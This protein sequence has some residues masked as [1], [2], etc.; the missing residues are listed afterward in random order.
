MK[1]I[2]NFMESN[3]RIRDSKGQKHDLILTNF[4]K[5]FFNKGPLNGKWSG[6]IVNK[7]R[8]L[9][10]SMLDGMETLLLSKIYPGS[11][12]PVI[13]TSED[14]AIH[15]MKL[16][17][18]MIDDCR[19]KFLQQKKGTEGRVWGKQFANKSEIQVFSGSNPKSIRGPK[20]LKVTL[21]EFAHSIYQKELL[22][23]ASPM[24]I[25]G[26]FLSTISTPMGINNEYWKMYKN[27]KEIGYETITQPIFEDMSKF[28]VYDS[29]YK[30]DLKVVAPW[31]DLTKLESDRIRDQIGFLQEYCCNPAESSYTLFNNDDLTNSVIQG[32]GFEYASQSA[33]RNPFTNQYV[34]TQYNWFSGHDFALS[35]ATGADESA[36]VIGAWND[37]KKRAEI[38]R[39][40][41]AKGMHTND[42]INELEKIYIDY[43]PTTMLLE[44]NTF[45]KSIFQSL[46]RKVP[47][48][49]P[50]HTSQPSKFELIRLIQ[51]WL[52]NS[53]LVIFGGRTEDESKEVSKWRTQMRAF[54]KVENKTG[55]GYKLEGAGEHDDYVMATGFFIKAINDFLTLG[56][57]FAA[58]SAATGK[59]SAA[60]NAQEIHSTKR[61]IYV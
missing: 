59:H 55:T 58:G 44:D 29:L 18:Q 17:N 10:Y 31:V 27:A 61:R 53:K 6:R 56:G 9:G 28:N 40:I 43:S 48:V 21:D 5:E 60:F 8:K 1:D 7:S 42:Q 14:Q 20:A 34:K 41:S 45:G 36:W 2:F 33:T 30:Q 22:D 51:E 13:A 26:G 38:R 50:F 4:Q 25:Q 3:F 32:K 23:A 52:A 47:V 16:L 11:F 15:Y 35:A 57:G 54:S 49:M 24:L 12:Y 37:E 46:Q 39:L 19:V